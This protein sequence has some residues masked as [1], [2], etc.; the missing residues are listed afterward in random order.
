MWSFA[1]E[2][3]VCVAVQ[4]TGWVK[5]PLVS[6]LAPADMA[7]AP[8]C[9]WWLQMCCSSGLLLK[10]EQQPCA[11]CAELAWGIAVGSKVVPSLFF[12]F[13][14]VLPPPSSFCVVVAVEAG[15]QTTYH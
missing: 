12:F 7:R 2:G 14:C 5:R 1:G 15:Y 8:G 11:W 4:R 3:S 10:I 6:S 13:S 9:I